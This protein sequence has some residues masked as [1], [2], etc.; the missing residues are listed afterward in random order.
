MHPLTLLTVLCA[1]PVKGNRKDGMIQIGMHCVTNVEEAADTSVGI[2]KAHV[3]HRADAHAPLCR[4]PKAGCRWAV[5]CS[6][7]AGLH[8]LPGAPRH[9]SVEKPTS[10]WNGTHDSAE[11]ITLPAAGGWGRYILSVSIVVDDWT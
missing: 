11:M 3:G 5:A 7:P 9:S 6:M 8:W 2:G 1:A 10:T 4:P